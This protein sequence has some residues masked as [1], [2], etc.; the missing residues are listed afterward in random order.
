MA[1]TEA[2]G[3]VQGMKILDRILMGYENFEHHIVRVRNL[4]EVL[5]LQ[6]ETAACS[7]KL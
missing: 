1:G 6:N 7:I 4:S 2:E 3:K 5:T